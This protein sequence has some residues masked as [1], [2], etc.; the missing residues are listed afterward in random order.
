M[1]WKS[2]KRVSGKSDPDEI[3]NDERA[4][5]AEIALTAFGQRTGMV[6]ESVGDDEDPF[7]IIAD[8]LADLAHWCD[9]HGVDLQE[10]LRRAGR[11]YRAEIGSL[12]KQL[13]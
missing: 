13:V 12:G 9:R 4:S 6:I 2:G 10:A 3:T 8:L 1:I 11:H 5:W 7:L